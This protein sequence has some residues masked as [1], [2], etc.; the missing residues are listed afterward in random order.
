MR[1]SADTD[2]AG[3]ERPP[4]TWAGP[5]RPRGTG[6]VHAPPS[7]HQSG[8]LPG[9]RHKAPSDLDDLDGHNLPSQSVLAAAPSING[10]GLAMN[11]RASGSQL[12]G[13]R[14]FPALVPALGRTFSGSP[15]KEIAVSPASRAVREPGSAAAIGGDRAG[16]ARVSGHAGQVGE[17]QV[18]PRDDDELDGCTAAGAAGL[19][20]AIAVVGLAVDLPRAAGRSAARGTSADAVLH[21]FAAD[22]LRGRDGLPP[23]PA[24]PLKYGPFNTAID[25]DGN[26]ID[27]HEAHLAHFEGQYWMYGR[28]WGCGTMSFGH[29]RDESARNDRPE[30]EMPRPDMRCFYTVGP[31]WRSIQ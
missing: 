14:S 3:R 6:V 25:V 13:T 16:E 5:H 2:T 9:G 23:S 15:G 10:G 7:V 11:A 21:N 22:L 24:F 19:A 17:V 20:L 4:R 27:A 18:L 28:E 26:A 8:A 30:C 29:L 12:R 1:A 31:R